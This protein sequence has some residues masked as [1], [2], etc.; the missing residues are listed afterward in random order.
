M[1]AHCRRLGWLVPLALLCV[2][3]V[4]AGGAWAAGV[5]DACAACH[6]PAGQGT[7]A[8]GAPRLAGLPAPY[9]QRQLQAF[10]RGTRAGAVMG[11]IARALSAQ[12]SAQLAARYARLPGL[13]ALAS[14]GHPLAA[15]RGGS[16]DSRTEL[17][18]LGAQLA[19]SGRWSEG[20][21]ACTQCHGRSGS[22]VGSDFPALAGQPAVY[23]EG[24]LTAW[25]RGL[26]DPGPMGLMGAIANKL[27]AL[28]IRA[29]AAY[30]AAG[31]GAGTESPPLKDPFERVVQLGQRIFDA[32]ASYAQAYVGNRLRCSSCHLD[33]G[34]RADSAPLWAAYVAYPAYRAKNG[35]VNTYAERLQGCFRYSMNGRPPPL[36]SPVLVAL[37]TYSYWLARGMRVDPHLPGRGYPRVPRPAL[38]ADFERGRRVYAQHCALC[39]GSNGAGQDAGDGSMAF[40]ALWGDGSFNWGA[41]MADVNNAAGFIQANMPLSHDHSLSDQQAWDV[42]LFMDAHER[43]QDPRFEGSVQATRARFHDTPDSMYGRRIGGHVLGVGAEPP[44]RA[45]G[46][47][48]PV[49][50]N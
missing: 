37:E 30:F 35:H 3:G 33:S 4:P 42:A 26:R 21:P 49:S 44:G 50:Q 9:L 15:G 31:S 14:A 47:R 40:P 1:D 12:E 7:V 17:L 10:A 48:V 46:A 24:Q 23:L 32:P 45:F 6:G 19:T 41:G 43:P 28:D 29:A 18:A 5:A 16:T 27:S 8:L 38:P 25:Q 22:G 11:P 13:P 20:L 39:H 34:R 36:G 2:L